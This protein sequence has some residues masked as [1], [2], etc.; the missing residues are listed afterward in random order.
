[1]RVIK[2]WAV[3]LKILS[4]AAI[5]ILK[6]LLWNNQAPKNGGVKK[7]LKSLAKSLVQM[8]GERVKILLYLGVFHHIVANKSRQR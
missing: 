1:M 5:S 3:I 7:I 4:Q 8:R 6:T 2:R